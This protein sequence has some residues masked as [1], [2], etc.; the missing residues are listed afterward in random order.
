MR[1]PYPGIAA[2]HAGAPIA[3]IAEL[4][5]PKGSFGG[6]GL[7]TVGCVRGCE[8]PT[9]ID[10]DRVVERRVTPPPE[11]SPGDRYDGRSSGLPA[12]YSTAEPQP[13]LGEVLRKGQV[14]MLVESPGGN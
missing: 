1:S 5:A 8:D 9:E 6:C 4:K 11:F 13:L 2:G 10:L 7:G 3:P 14:W 12:V